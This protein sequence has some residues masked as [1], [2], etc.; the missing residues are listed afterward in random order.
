MVHPLEG[1]PRSLR[2]E[3]EDLPGALVQ[4]LVQGLDHRPARGFVVLELL[5]DGLTVARDL[6]IQF[7]KFQISNI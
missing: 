2:E 6:S 4:P 5:Q 7:D 1:R 3:P